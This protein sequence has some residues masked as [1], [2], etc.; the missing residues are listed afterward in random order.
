[1]IGIA[2]MTVAGSPA[3]AGQVGGDSIYARQAV[4][5]IESPKRGRR[6]GTEISTH[7]AACNIG[8]QLNAY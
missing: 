4:Y 6:R 8:A 3:F 2:I 5:V 1:M 7:A